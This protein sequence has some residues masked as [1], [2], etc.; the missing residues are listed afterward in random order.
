VIPEPAIQQPVP[1]LSS[2]SHQTG[3]FFT[4]RRPPPKNGF[5]KSKSVPT[6]RGADISGPLPSHTLRNRNHLKDDFS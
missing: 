6:I 1:E 5:S 4:L 3:S 2:T